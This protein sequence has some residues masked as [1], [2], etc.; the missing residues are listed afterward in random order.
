MFTRRQKFHLSYNRLFLLLR[1]IRNIKL[2]EGK[3]NKLRWNQS[4]IN[5]FT[6]YF[7]SQCL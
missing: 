5:S 1:P 6:A 4:L 3:K 7:I 2:N